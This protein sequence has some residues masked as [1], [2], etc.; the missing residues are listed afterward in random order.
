VRQAIAA[1]PGSPPELLKRGL[2]DGIQFWDE[3]IQELGGKERLVKAEDYQEVDPKSLGFAPA[4]RFALIYGSGN[5]VQGRGVLSR[6][7]SPVFASDTVSEAL[8]DAAEDE[9]VQAIILRIDSP[10]GSPLAADQIWRAARQAQAAG[11]PVIASFSDVAASAAYY[12][13]AGADAIVA[14]P[15]SLTG[16]IGV[17]VLRPTVRE[18]L[19]E[20]EIGVET[21]TRGDY[22]SLLLSSQPLTDSTRGWLHAEVGAI[23]DLFLAR[24][25]EGR[26]LSVEAVDAVGRGRVWTGEEAARRGL[27]DELGGLRAAVVFTLRKL[28]LDPTADVA[29][30]PFPAPRSLAEQLDEALRDL[31]V[32]AWPVARTLRRAEPWLE[33]LRAGAPALLPPVLPEIR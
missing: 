2:I 29:L 28:G 5:V 1:A 9:S 27:V 24:V 19:E 4:A 18:L 14:P 26:E 30:V 11:K 23:Y 20:F 3:L 6:T 25:S 22:A 17:F 8:A 21:F 16:S 15:A 7:G 31:S 10:G 32:R 12:V 13:A 33:A